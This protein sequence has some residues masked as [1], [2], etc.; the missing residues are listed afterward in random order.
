MALVALRGTAAGRVIG[1]G[2]AP[3]PFPPGVTLCPL[4]PASLDGMPTTA[5]TFTFTLRVTDNQGAQTSEQ[6]RITIQPATPRT[7]ATLSSLAVSPACVTAGTATTGTVSLSGP[8]PASGATVFLPN[9]EPS[10]ATRPAS[11]TIPAGSMATS[12]SVSTLPVAMTTTV[13]IEAGYGGQNQFAELTVFGIPPPLPVGAWA[14]TGRMSTSR[15]DD[16]A[17][18]LRTGQVLVVGGGVTGAELYS[19]ATGAWT[20]TGRMSTDRAQHTAT[21][22]P[23]GAVLVAGGR[24]SG[25]VALSSAELYHPATGTWTLTGSMH[26]ARTAAGATLLRTGQVLVAGGDNSAS[27]P[28]TSA[29]LYNPATGLWIRTGRMTTARS[30]P[31]ATPLGNGEVLVAGGDSASA[32]LASA[33]LYNPAAPQAQRLCIATTRP[34]GEEPVLAQSVIRATMRNR[35]SDGYLKRPAQASYLTGHGLAVNGGLL[36]T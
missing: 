23:N 21:L 5:G 7:P 22:L 29:E 2:L 19:P 6:S 18:L 11:V 28:L 36:A 27:T 25:S 17:T 1:D 14:L 20:P 31:S 12:F 9:N 32:V 35:S 13:Q 4:A 34:P 16:T 30:E 8:A 24:S 33:E 15:V 10:V 26:D 3:I